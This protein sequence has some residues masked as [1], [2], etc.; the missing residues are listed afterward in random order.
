MAAP[1]LPIL[2]TVGRVSKHALTHWQG[3]LA[4]AGLAIATSFSFNSF[5]QQATD[6]ALALWPILSLAC[7]FLLLREFIKGW[8]AVKKQEAT[9]EKG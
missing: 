5:L 3:L 2:L 9:K 4:F 8:L 1:L 6:S 7:F